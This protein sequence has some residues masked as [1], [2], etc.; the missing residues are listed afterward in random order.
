MESPIKPRFMNTLPASNSLRTVIV[1]FAGLCAFRA[2]AA[3][4]S[5]TPTGSMASGR[6]QHSATLLGDGTILIAGGYSSIGLP[7]KTAEIFDPASGTCRSLSPAAMHSGRFQHTATLLPN[8]KVL[9]AGGETENF[10]FTNT[11]EL[12]DPA[13]KTFT[14]LPNTMALT[15]YGHTATLLPNGKVLIAGGDTGEGASVTATNAAELFDP[16]S[17]TFTSLPP[18]AAARYYHTATLLSNGKVLLAGGKSGSA[19]TSTAELFD[20]S[21]GTFTLLP[22][23]MTLP[24]ITHTATL[25]TSGKVLI[26]GGFMIGYEV[27][28]TA[29]LFDPA[30]GTFTVVA[31]MTSVRYGHTATLLPNGKVLL[32]GGGVGA[33]ATTGTAELFD[34]DSQSFT[35]VSPMSTMRGYHTAMLLPSGKIL[36]CGGFQPSG[37]TLTD[38]RTQEL[39]D[40]ASATFTAIAPMETARHHHTAT[41]LPNGKIL[42]AG[43]W[44]GSTTGNAA[45]VFDPVLRTFTSVSSMATGRVQHTA[46]LLPNGKVLIAGGY[47]LTSTGLPPTDTAELF[48]PASGTFKSVSPMNLGRYAHTATLLSNGKVL[49]AG[50]YYPLPNGGTLFTN[51]AE[52]FDPVSETFK[53]V[54]PMDLARANHVATR[55]PNG[56]VLITGGFGGLDGAEAEMFDPDSETFSL[57]SPMNTLRYNGHSATLLP[58]GKVL[59]AGG[60]VGAGNDVSTNTAEVFDPV[61]GIFTAISPMNVGRVSHTATL[62]PSGM[63]LI[64]GGDL[65][66]GA[67]AATNTAELFDPATGIFTSLSPSTM[68]SPRHRHTAT[69]LPDGTVLVA[70]GVTGTTSGTTNTAE[71]FNLGLGFSDARRPVITSVSNVIQPASLAVTGTGFRGDSEGGSGASYNSSATNYPLLQLM[72]IENEQTF[73]VLSNPATNWS[74]TTFSSET[75]GAV[76]PLPSGYYRVTIFTNAIPSVQKIIKIGTPAP[77]QLAGLASRKVHGSAGTFDVDLPLDGSG[78]ECRSG[79]ANGGYTLVFTFPNNTSVASA[80]V[81]SGTGTVSSSALGPNPNQYTV[82]LTGVTNAQYLTVTLNGLIDAA[83]NSSSTL[84]GPQMG[85]LVGDVNASGVVTSGDTNLCKAQALQQVTN[86][87]FRND[88]N[89]SGS[90][91]TGDVNLIKQ[92]ALSQLPP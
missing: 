19:T 37:M 42:L 63:V 90:I 68:T 72:R 23:T 6:Y 30:T 4:L 44:T 83:G 33:T 8:G 79:E 57:V 20:P 18:M 13:S 60:N 40:A 38:L 64:A 28:N 17:G 84:V 86:A 46:T 51:T 55:L 1:V 10:V 77:V 53:S 9:I 25:L 76:T 62:L 74:D 80:S 27:W 88:I 47:T 59:I 34:P 24:R 50:G 69:V 41:I 29:E 16:E 89:G 21:S 22:N 75:L 49:L 73:F 66:Q 61:S 15:R 43:G 81:T 3:P 35:A 5:F 45:E 65:T 92:N 31:P 78:I 11:A 32:A 82:N 71:L 39:F 12:F 7:R 70:G 87:N 48:D 91:T 26:T 36:I 67:S 85:V 58:S 52:L 2:S 56:K 14:L 54:A